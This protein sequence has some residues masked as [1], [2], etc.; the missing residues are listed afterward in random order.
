MCRSDN[1]L[2]AKWIFDHDS[3]QT[4]GHILFYAPRLS[5]CGGHP[6][7][8][9]SLAAERFHPW[10]TACHRIDSHSDDSHSPTVKVSTPQPLKYR[11]TKGRRV[12]GSTGQRIDDQR[13]DGRRVHGKY[14]RHPIRYEFFI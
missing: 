6:P 8:F 5:S 11:Q 4:L 14:G 1:I 2:G 12:K 7:L 10:G 13:T 9:P 3:K